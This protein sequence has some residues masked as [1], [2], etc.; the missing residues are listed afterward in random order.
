MSH[1][2]SRVRHESRR[3]TVVVKH[4]EWI[5]P[6]MKRIRF[7]ED[8]ADFTSL[9][10]DDHLKIFVPD[11]NGELVGRDYTPRRF[12]PG[13]EALDIDFAMHDAGPVTAWARDAKAGDRIG[14]GGPRG[15]V[16]VPNDFDWWLLVGDETAL[17]AIGRRLEEMPAGVPVTA[18]MAVADASEQQTFATRADL[19]AIW[20][21]RAPDNADAPGPLIE[22][23]RGFTAPPGEGYVWIAAEAN[24]ARALRR[25]VLEEMKH[26]AQWLKASGYW[27]KGKADASEKSIA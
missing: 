2:I 24:V 23:L 12:D 15:S 11:G 1:E 6:G 14:I 13:H 20:V 9:S 21:H 10:A 25:Q 7:G 19:T 8:L 18:I 4:A 17:P 3:R 16:V 22:A 27:V 5:T 26:P